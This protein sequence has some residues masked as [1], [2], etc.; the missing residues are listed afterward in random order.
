MCV[1]VGMRVWC[2]GGG[3]VRI[4][5]YFRAKKATDIKTATCGV[6]FYENFPDFGV[7]LGQLR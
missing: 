1:V 5:G 4:L 6:F 7:R 2:A 3:I